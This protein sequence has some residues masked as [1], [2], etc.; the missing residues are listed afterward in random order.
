M[1]PKTKRILVIT[2]VVL[3]LLILGGGLYVSDYYRAD[4]AAQSALVSDDAV[5]IQAENGRILFQP[6]QPPDAGLI[7]YPGGK[8][9]Y[10]AY[11]P[12]LRQLAEKGV[13]CVL[14]KMP[15]NLA[16]LDI[17]AAR[18]IPE[19][20]PEISHWYLAGHSLGGSM[21]ASYCAKH[22]ESFEGLIL[23][24]SYSTADLHNSGLRVLSLYGS[25]DGV[26]NREKY[27][28]YSGNLPSDSVQSVLAGGNHC[29]FGS[30]G[31][32][33]GDNPALLS[34]QEQATQ[35]AECIFA[36]LQEGTAA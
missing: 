13:F 22:S 31:F 14:V 5:H 15:A 34:P 3:A 11:A 26:M 1:K 2:A 29:G 33:K 24:A 9:E 25:E 10:T 6:S 8:V 19:A 36:F 20:F 30:Y 21:A 17:S 18:G 4:S 28:K 7:F 12:L 16:V 32:Q 27:E 35:A 23:L